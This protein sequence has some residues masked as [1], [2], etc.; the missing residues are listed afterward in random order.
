MQPEVYYDV[1]LAD[2]ETIIEVI[3]NDLSVL[4]SG[5]LLHWKNKLQI[6]DMLYV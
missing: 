5:N 6:I 2:E 1:W 4:D 3:K